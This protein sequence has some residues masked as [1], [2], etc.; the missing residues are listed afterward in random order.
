MSNRQDEASKLAGLLGEVEEL[1][2]SRVALLKRVEHL[3]AG[4]IAAGDRATAVRASVDLLCDHI[5]DLVNAAA[6]FSMLEREVQEIEQGVEQAGKDVAGLEFESDSL[7]Q[8][9]NEGDDELE[10]L[11]SILLERRMKHLKGH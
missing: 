6:E 1:E 11:S 8:A 3:R 10:R 9:L 7:Q 2:R 5:S 4:L